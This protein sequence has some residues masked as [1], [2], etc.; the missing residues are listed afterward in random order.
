MT[1]GIHQS[2]AAKWAREQQ[3]LHFCHCGCGA[4]IP[5]TFYHY[6]EG[7]PNYLNHHKPPD[8]VDLGSGKNKRIYG[9]GLRR[10]SKWSRKRRHYYCKLPGFRSMVN[11][12]YDLALARKFVYAYMK[13]HRNELYYTRLVNLL[14]TI[15]N[16]VVE[17]QRR[18]ASA[19]I[20][21]SLLE[22]EQA[23]KELRKTIKQKQEELGYGD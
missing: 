19:R 2:K 7:I 21:K 4:E 23:L 20:D 15:K 22:A 16:H 10:D 14:R 9:G 18:L 17:D 8:I 13:A 1:R 5:V 11:L 12:G 6:Y 3:G